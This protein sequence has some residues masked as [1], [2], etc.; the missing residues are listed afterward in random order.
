MTNAK[1]G[2]TAAL[3]LL[4]TACGGGSASSGEGTTPAAMTPS[5]EASGTQLFDAIGVALERYPSALPYEVEIDDETAHLGFLEV[6]LWVGDEAK[7]VF[8]D[9]GTMA[10]VDE[11]MDVASADEDAARTE[12]HARLVSGEFTL[13]GAFEAGLLNSYDASHVIEVEMTI[14]DGHPVIGVTQNTGGA[15]SY[16]DATGAHLG[17]ADEAR[18]R[19]AS[20]AQLAGQ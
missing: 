7:E 3:A 14:L 11:G 8:I 18:A 12:I 16:H 17:T 5:A 19:W 20:E 2:T 15:V 13:R 4:M 9:P 10:I 1:L 6:E